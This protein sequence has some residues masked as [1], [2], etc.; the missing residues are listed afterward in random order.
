MTITNYKENTMLKKIAIVLAASALMA[1]GEEAVV[2]TDTAS[3]AVTESAVVE[4]M[5]ENT[6]EAMVPKVEAAPIVDSKEVVESKEVVATGSV[7]EG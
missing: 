5:V 7:E 6:D 2:A 3:E 1:C 4:V